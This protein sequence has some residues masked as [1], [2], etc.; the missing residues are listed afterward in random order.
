ME[1][2][3]KQIQTLKN[4]LVEISSRKPSIDVE[5]S[6]IQAKLQDLEG[7]IKKITR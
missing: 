1:S 5:K 2:I 6:S 4:E 7:D 3:E